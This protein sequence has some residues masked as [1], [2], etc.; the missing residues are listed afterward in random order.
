M[1][2]SEIDK[3]FEIGKPSVFDAVVYDAS[4]PPFTTYGGFSEE[5]R[6]FEK[7]PLVDSPKN[8]RGRCVGQRVRRGNKNNLCYQLFKYKVARQNQK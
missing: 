4:K 8:R 3:N 1:D 5:Q 6:K 7:M 2:V